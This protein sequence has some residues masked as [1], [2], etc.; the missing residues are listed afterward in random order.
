ME[1]ERPAEPAD[2]DEEVDELRLGR[3]HLGELVDDEEERRHRRE[4][5]ARGPRP[6]VVADRCEVACF[7]QQLLPTHHLA[8]QRVLHAVDQGQLLGQVGDDGRDVGHLGHAGKG[9]ATLEVDQHHVELLGGVGH[10]QAEHER[11]QELRL[12]G[13]GRADHQAVRAHALLRALLDVEVDHAPALAEADRDAEPVARGPWPPGGIRVEDVDVSQTEQV[14]EVAGSRDLAAGVGGLSRADGVERGEPSCE[15]L[16]RGQV[17][18]VA[19]RLD[20][21][22]AHPDGQHRHLAPVVLPGGQ[23][24]PQPARVVELVPPGRQVQHGDAVQ[25]VRR[26]DVVAGRQRRAVGHEQDVGGGGTLVGTEAGPVAQVGREH[27]GEVLEGGRHDPL[28]PDRV[29]LLRALGVRQPL[30]PVPVDQVAVGRQHRHHEVLGGVE[31]R[32]RADHRAGQSADRVL[33]A[34]QLDPVERPQVDAGRQVGLEPVD[35]QQPVEGRGAR[36]VD[37][38]DRRALRRDELGRERLGAG[39]VADL[40]EVLVGAGVLP[41]PRPLLGQRRERHRVGV[42]PGQRPPLLVG[43]LAR[44]LS[45]VAEVAEV[46]GP[47][48]GDLLRA[49]LTLPV[50]LDHDE[51]QGGEEEHAGGDVAAAGVGLPLPGHRGHQHD[52]PEA[53][54]HGDGVHDD[55]AG[56]L[57]LLDLGRWLQHDLAG[58]HLRLVQPR[59]PK[60][61]A[62][63]LPVPRRPRWVTIGDSGRSRPPFPGRQHRVDHRLPLGA[64]GPE[65]PEAD[66]IE[67]EGLPPQAEALVGRQAI[68]LGEE[69]GRLAVEVDVGLSLGPR[70]PGG[71]PARG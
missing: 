27:R 21:L 61:G 56:A 29:G 43:G 51:A 66:R 15:R 67:L 49:L 13:A 34:A 30:E 47:G 6:L 4:V 70:R 69:V 28:R 3:Q 39:A 64:A 1:A 12:A 33:L 52:R 65:D 68:G 19:G 40:E 9:R 38:V 14:H 63:V 55:A 23:L 24:Q 8:R 10:R 25:T 71:P 11:A 20:R 26:Y 42:V 46:L 60:R 32:R 18:L 50:D 54:E 31:R 57:A 37:L 7:A 2:R 16:G 35:H 22:L 62:H 5:L 48:A 36:R 45:D 53:A 44:D 41:H 58:R 59:S 17:A